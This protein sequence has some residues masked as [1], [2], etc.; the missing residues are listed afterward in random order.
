MD[1]SHRRT[2]MQAGAFL[3]EHLIIEEMNALL[4]SGKDNL[5]TALWRINLPIAESLVLAVPSCT[6]LKNP[7]NLL[8]N[9]HG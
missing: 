9:P 1:I 6:L 7:H 8:V 5:L 2:A 4:T 3:Q